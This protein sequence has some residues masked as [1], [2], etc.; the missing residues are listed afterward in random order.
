MTFVIAEVGSNWKTIDDCKHSIA[1]AKN[2][3]ADAVKFQLYTHE[4]LFGFSGSIEGAMPPEWLPMLKE[5]A[6]ACGIEFMCT[7]FSSELLE[8]VNPLVNYHKLASSELCH[9]RMLEKLKYINKPTFVSTGGHILKDVKFALDVLGDTPVTLMH[10]VGEYPTRFVNLERMK[11]LDK[12]FDC[13]VGLSDHTTIIDLVAVEAVKAGATA[14]EKHVNFAGCDGPD[15]PH[16]LS[17]DEFGQ[18]VR[19]IREEK[20]VV[21]YC[22][23]DM[24]LKNNRR[25]IAIQNIKAGDLLR[26]KVNFGLHRSTRNDEAGLSPLLAPLVEGK[27]AMTA[28]KVGDAITPKVVKV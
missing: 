9:L 2:T 14:I 8:L 5:K 17:T 18:M 22:E 11:D 3:G 16:S 7:A 19:C 1:M 10:C 26:E 13:P 28:V 27:P 12:E 20:S 24:V 23:K 6:T 4:A 21:R 15:A 25:L